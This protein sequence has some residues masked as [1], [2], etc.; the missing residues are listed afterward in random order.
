[1]HGFVKL[2]GAIVTSSVWCEDSDTRVVWVTLL[3]TA[4]HQGIV[5][6]AVPGLARLANVPL[7]KTEAALTKFLS[8][9]PYS[10]SKDHDGRRL[11]VVAGGWRILNY[12][13]YRERAQDRDGGRAP[14]MRAYRARTKGGAPAD[15]DL[16]PEENQAAPGG[17]SESDGAFCDEEET[18]HDAADVEHSHA[19]D[20]GMTGQEERPL[21]GA[22]TR[23]SGVLRV[24][25]IEETNRVQKSET[26]ELLQQR[27]RASDSR[28]RPAK[29]SNPLVNR[30]ARLARGYE[31]IRVISTH[32][33]EDPTETLARH[34][35]GGGR[36]GGAVAVSLDAMGD[37]WLARTVLSMEAEHAEIAA[38]TRRAEL[39][40]VDK[41]LDGRTVEDIAF[42]LDGMTPQE[43][44]EWEGRH[45]WDAKDTTASRVPPLVA[46]LVCNLAAA[47]RDRRTRAEQ[48]RHAQPLLDA[49]VEY[50]RGK[51]HAHAF[52]TWFRPLGP[53]RID[54]GKIRITVPTEQFKAGLRGYREL[55]VEAAVHSLSGAYESVVVEID[56][57]AEHPPPGPMAARARP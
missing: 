27:A 31:L 53:A 44:D 19:D 3:A 36:L 21:H 11:E 5:Q 48:E 50:L 7:D 32:R 16:A 33:R 26:T 15:G 24:T 25:Q 17:D 42:A 12:E 41:W 1:M 47:A 28:G 57:A 49:M 52:G 39:S 30:P 20:P 14:Y 34:S 37:D 2:F 18:F 9:D 38:A 55:L 46:D 40:A 13:P 6:A 10:R 43:L 23:N 8:P 54:G 51:V 56:V 45:Q 4:N 35:S 22:V 29:P